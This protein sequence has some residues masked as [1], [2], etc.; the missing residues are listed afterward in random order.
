L[1]K[2]KIMSKI[3][4]VGWDCSKRKYVFGFY[5]RDDRVRYIVDVNS[6]E[7]LVSESILDV[8]MLECGLYVEKRFTEFSCQ[9]AENLIDIMRRKEEDAMD[10]FRR[11]RD[12]A[13]KCSSEAKKLGITDVKDGG[14]L[15]ERRKK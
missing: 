4:G 15:R 5:K 10:L 14:M 11:L 12:L 13:L 9:P 7:I 3:I 8:D 2:E 6:G 1:G